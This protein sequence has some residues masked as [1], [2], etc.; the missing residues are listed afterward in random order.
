MLLETQLMEK[1]QYTM[2]LDSR[3]VMI[4]DGA[5]P[6]QQRAL[7][8]YLV[9]F[10]TVARASGWLF[11]VS[12]S[13]RRSRAQHLL[14]CSPPAARGTVLRAGTSVCVHQGHV[15]EANKPMQSLGR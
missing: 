13:C 1:A 6:L 7:E 11:C 14:A 5:W 8:T 3:V 10:I 9:Y 2:L 15:H 4:C 12:C